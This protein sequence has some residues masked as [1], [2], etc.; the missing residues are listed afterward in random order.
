MSRVIDKL[1]DAGVS[2]TTGSA[3]GNVNHPEFT[4]CI[5]GKLHSG[6]KKSDYQEPL[7]AIGY[8]LVDEVSKGLNY[9]V[10]ADADSGSSK[11]EKAKKLGIK[12]ISEAQLI[13]MVGEFASQ[14]PVS[15]VDLPIQTSIVSKPSKENAMTKPSTPLSVDASAR[16]FEFIDEKSAKFWEID[17]I[18]ESVEVKFGKI[19][20]NGQTQ[21]K[22]FESPD[23]AFMHAEKLVHEKLK[24]GYQEVVPRANRKVP[25]ALTKLAPVPVKPIPVKAKATPAPEKSVPGS[26]KVC[27]SGKLP[28]GSK[29]SD[30]EAPLL[31][32]GYS[33]VDDVVHDLTYLVLADPTSTSSK[34]EK[35]R[36]LGVEV[37]SEEELQGLL[38][39]NND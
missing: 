12:V 27:I 13:E 19:G 20:T 8:A 26:K 15:T 36:K 23:E 29:K 28:S 14:E 37:L 3:H 33:L 18:A 4:V 21:I 11:A 38:S 24:N 1:L 22:N 10:L 7:L 16:R 6:R 5:S 25:Q 34:A 17:V 39:T 2:I 35:A 31:A 32:A 9:L 30:Y